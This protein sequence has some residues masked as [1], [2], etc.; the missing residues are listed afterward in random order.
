MDGGGSAAVA[1]TAAVALTAAV[2][3]VRDR[4]GN[5]VGAG[6]L[7]AEGLLV[8][9]AHVLEDGGYGPGDEAE[10]VFPRVPGAPAVRGRV[11]AEG[12]RDAQGQDVAL[13][14]LEHV[15]PGTAVL[16]LGSSAACG[17]HRVRAFGFP[18]QA[19]PDGHFGAA[20]AVGVL[21]PTGGVGEL[22]QLTGANDLTTGFSGGPVLDEVTGLVVG[23]LT[24]ITAPDGYDRGAGI[25]HAT[26][27]SVL[28]GAWPALDI[29]DV[30]PYRALEPFTAEH[31]RWF[32][33]R[34]EAVRQVLAGLSGGQRVVLL[35]GP[36][37]SGKSSLVQAGVLPALADGRLPGSDRWRQTVVRPGPDLDLALGR[38][39]PA[40]QEDRADRADRRTVLV[41]DQFEELLAPSAGPEAAARLAGITA[42][43]RS[44]APLCTVLVVR[45]DFYPRLS[46]LAPE[47]LRTALESGGVLN[48]P[49]VLTADELDA[50][51]TGPARDLRTPFET[52][53]A[54]QIV[55]DVLALNPVDPVNPVNPASGAPVTALPLLEVALTRLWER[56]HDHDG[57]LTHDAYRRTGGVTGALT[58]WCEAALRELG[59]QRRPV[60]QR[61]LTALVRPADEA[62][63]VPAAR[64]QRPL[65]ELRDLA[66]ADDTPAAA[67][68]VDEVLAVLSRH[69]ILTTHRAGDTPVAELIHDALIRDW[70]TLHDWVEQDA[71]FNDWLDRA[72]TRRRHWQRQQPGG[73]DA[74]DLPAGSF[75]A[76]GTDWSARRR[77]PAH[78]ADFLAEGRHHEQAAARRSRRLNTVL[79][80][81]LALALL[82][83][84]LAAWQW[85]TATNA[86]HTAQSRQLAAQ[87]ALLAG[88]DPDLA[89]LLAVAA[90]RTGPTEEAA[91][92]LNA[93]ASVPLLHRFVVGGS[94]GAVPLVAFSPDG[95]TLATYEEEDRTVSLWNVATGRATG[96]RLDYDGYASAMAFSPDGR[97]LVLGGEADLQLWDTAT[98]RTTTVPAE[99]HGVMDAMAFTPDGRTLV[100]DSSDG[101]TW[102]WDVAG[103][104]GDTTLSGRATT[105]T[106]ISGVASAAFSPDGRTLARGSRD[107]T[108][109]VWDVATGAAGPTFTGHTRS[110][111]AVAFSPD[112]R[113]LAS[114]SQDGTVRL[115]DAATGKAEAVLTGHTDAVTSVAFSPDGRLLATGGQDGTVRL[116]DTVTGKA[117]TVL[118]SRPGSVASVA[119]SPDGR[120]LATGGSGGVGRL[121][122]V[123]TR[124]TDAILTGHT[125]TVHSVAFSPDGRT[126]AT[127]GSDETTRLWDVATGRST[128]TLGTTAATLTGNPALA[129]VFSP[130][131]RTV[132][133]G[134]GDGVVRLWDA[135]TGAPGATFTGHTGS[136]YAVAF[137][138]D[139]RTL[140]S[141]SWD[142]TMRLWDAA[143]GRAEAVFDVDAAY[144]VAFSP[145]G[146]TL[147]SGSQDGTVRLW[148]AA[149]GR[150]EV[151]LTGHV[152]ILTSLA[153][154]PDGRTLASGSKDGTVR[155]WDAATGRAEAVLTGHVDIVTSLAFSPDGRTLAS[156]STD[157][158]VRLWDTETRKAVGTFG[159]TARRVFSVAFS[160]DGRTVAA[161]DY[162]GSVRL[163]FHTT[164]EAAIPALCK[165]VDRDLTPAE[166]AQ[167]LPDRT[168]QAVCPAAD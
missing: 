58:D 14:R 63:R 34:E 7:V 131:G 23:M 147:A 134:S 22:L 92:A 38:V 54:R 109:R 5:V 65:G 31:A 84:G 77:L 30:S 162:G 60:A 73:R 55:A 56:R 150:A 146:R 137:A 3:Q 154:S 138:P 104:P 142:G 18:T 139:G 145:D 87:S 29:G 91:A 130:D 164:P 90:Y 43:V 120:T 166:R 163:W 112:G 6:F 143:T 141:G 50:I 25:A 88:T 102:Q 40:H 28:R 1:P 127:A 67:E 152:D 106:D 12:W 81:L 53:L 97:T 119:F 17:G 126:L 44:D 4:A 107:G 121:W 8:S 75:L 21:P 89:A 48:V 86:Q 33:G 94:G 39:V 114:G 19:R 98:G 158:T 105:R 167:Y 10:L 66:A 9:C 123:S 144:A 70:R 135:A 124:T 117:V 80:T 59:E 148:D 118:T 42:A 125:S 161:G 71:R 101:T 69:R 79:A 165:A 155:L 13:V 128:A 136:V 57:R 156:G 129:V 49:A 15:P 20:V 16:P 52:G 115:W 68:A 11:L 159:T 160:P 133:T 36:S 116:W 157:G 24:E 153:F 151:V 96:A 41:V 35:L 51:V 113:T 111:S 85:R 64:R 168:D 32:R 110:V 122:N 27:T 62:L 72:E 61:I 2:A 83:S 46:A 99:S 108:A 74:R 93:A 45:D 47:L 140:A 78:V 103:A 26:P 132:A 100:T 82:A 95:R 149:T 76:E 37:G